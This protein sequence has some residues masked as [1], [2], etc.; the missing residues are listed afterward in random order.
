MLVPFEYLWIPSLF[1]AVF[2]ALVLMKFVNL[3][4][5][6]ALT[7]GL[8]KAAIPFIYFAHYYDGSWNFIDDKVY[9]EK[10][11]LMLWG[12][13]NPLLIFFTPDGL[14]RLV[15]AAESVH[16]LYYWWNL[17]AMYIF[18]P[19]YSSPIFLN[20]FTTFVSAALLYRIVCSSGFAERYARWLTIFLLFH[21]DVL[22][23]SSLINL[24]DTLIM[25]LT[26]VSIFCGLRF[27]QTRRLHYLV[28]SIATMFVFVW[29]RLYI[30]VLLLGSFGLW[31]ALSFKGWKRVSW[32]LL[33]TFC[34]WLV[35]PEGEIQTLQDVFV[36]DWL[37][38]PFRMAL[39]PQP[40][41]ITSD[42]SFLL[43][44]SIFHW[45]LFVPA[46]IVG[47]RLALKNQIFR[48][49][50]IYFAVMIVFYGLIP[51][52]QGPRQ[53]LQVSWIMAWA[54]FDVLWAVATATVQK[55]S[56]SR[57]TVAR[58]HRSQLVNQ[59]I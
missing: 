4:W 17:L 34:I 11:R 21:W 6:S 48:L 3:R 7:I 20:V 53:R 35:F 51:E 25:M 1:V 41:S 39:T 23:W 15:G 13:N 8:L 28:V 47:F 19:F 42:Y 10:G 5:W 57:R 43:I 33:A 12:G 31:L 52:E 44:P 55:M 54:Q 9:F 24:K 2:G 59:K 37:F 26:L 32:V 56:A 46:A 40:W 58:L 36:A 29:I 38:G 49:V 22:T 18:G 14:D 30:P 27:I 16:F 50:A 45:A